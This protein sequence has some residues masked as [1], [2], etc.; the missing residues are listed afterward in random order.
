MK[1]LITNCVKSVHI[2]SYSG[3][4]FPAFGLNMERYSISLQIQSKC[5][6]MQTRIT[7]NTDTLYALT[8]FKTKNVLSQHFQRGPRLN[9]WEFL[10]LDFATG[11]LTYQFSYR[12]FSANKFS[13]EKICNSHKQSNNI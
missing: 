2:Q 7:L 4:H 5:G 12:L 6:K 3:P 10:S 9:F 13:H 8:C 1:A 11:S